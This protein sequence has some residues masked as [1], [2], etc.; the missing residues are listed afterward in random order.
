MMPVIDRPALDGS[1][2]ESHLRAISNPTSRSSRELAIEAHVRPA[3]PLPPL[4]PEGI[5]K[6]AGILSGDDIVNIAVTGN[7]PKG[8]TTRSGTY[9]IVDKKSI[10]VLS[11]VVLPEVSNRF[12]AVR[13]LLKV[14][15][16]S[17]VYDIGTFGENGEFKPAGFFSVQLSDASPPIGPSGRAT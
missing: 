1:H 12:D 16:A 13:M 17:G 11:Q 10:A 5:A 8:E 15:R 14:Q 9:F 7:V 6:Y 2:L 4:T 3:Q